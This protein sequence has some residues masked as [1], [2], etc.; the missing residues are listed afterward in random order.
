MVKYRCG[1][2]ETDK[3]VS[4]YECS[5]VGYRYGDIGTSEVARLCE[6]MLVMDRKKTRNKNLFCY[7]PGKLMVSYLAFVPVTDSNNR[8]KIIVV[9]LW[10]GN[11]ITLCLYQGRSTPFALP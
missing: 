9:G 1:D 7:E 3:I 11:D 10:L 8:R 4:W 5:L 2:F 6:D